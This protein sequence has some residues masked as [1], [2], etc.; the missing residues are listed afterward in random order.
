MK[1]RLTN[2]QIYKKQGKSYYRGIK[3]P[4]IP[5]SSNDLYVTTTAGDRLDLLA[6]YFYKDYKLW[7]IIATGNRDLVRRDSYYVKPGIEIRI[8]SNVEQIIENY[9]IINNINY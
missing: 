4:N 6:N 9:R 7:W 1:N 3:Y 8:P 5:L 2:I